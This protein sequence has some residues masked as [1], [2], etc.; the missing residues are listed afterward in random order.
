MRKALQLNRLD[1]HPLDASRQLPASVLPRTREKLSTAFNRLARADFPASELPKEENIQK[2]LL[3][4][5]K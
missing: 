4:H 1:C 2:Q 3:R 5:R